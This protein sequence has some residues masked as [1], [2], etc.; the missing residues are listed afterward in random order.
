MGAAPSAPF[1]GFTIYPSVGSDATSCIVLNINIHVDLGENGGIAWQRSTHAKPVQVGNRVGLQTSTVGPARGTH[2]ENM[3]VTL[4]LPH[5]GGY[6]NDVAI[7]LI[8]PTFEE[9][10]AKATFARFLA[11]F[12]AW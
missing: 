7:T 5:D 8:T 9:K 1:H 11:S 2:F 12:R 3:T 10:K 4:E 6:K